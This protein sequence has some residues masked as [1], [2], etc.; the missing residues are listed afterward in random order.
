[1][2]VGP[3][4]EP[5]GDVPV[6]GGNPPHAGLGGPGELLGEQGPDVVGDPGRD[7]EPIQSATTQDSVGSVSSRN[8][9]EFM[10]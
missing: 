8:D 10:Q 4:E 2:F 6:V 3:T 5:K 9:A 1:M 7:E